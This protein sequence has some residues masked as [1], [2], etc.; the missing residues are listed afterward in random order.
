MADQ[1]YDFAEPDPPKPKPPE[2]RPK[3]ASQTPASG[4]AAPAANQPAP[5][6]PPKPPVETTCRFCGFIMKGPPKPRCPECAAPMDKSVADLIKFADSAWVRGLSTGLLLITVA[7]ALHAG[8]AGLRYGSIPAAGAAHVLAAAIFAAGTFMLTRARPDQPESNVG[9]KMARAGSIGVLILWLPVM[10]LT[11]KPIG[12]YIVLRKTLLISTLLVQALCAVIIGYH[13]ARLASNIP[14]DSLPAQSINSGWLVLVLCVFFTL[15][16]VLDLS[17]A[18]YMTLFFC[19]F[20]LI[21]GLIV[22]A[23]WVIITAIRMALE[24]K[25]SAVEGEAIQVRR[26]QRAAGIKPGPPAAKAKPQ[27]QP[28]G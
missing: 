21:A 15:V 26:A 6:E 18:G 25:T 28:P 22:A 9:A 17:L 5:L 11:F 14:D 1:S 23:V 12:T 27:S 2:R 19:S 16:Q 20:P 8:G 24:L 13:A 4:T 10:A 3:P 7:I